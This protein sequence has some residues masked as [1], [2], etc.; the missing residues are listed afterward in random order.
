[1]QQPET[2]VYFTAV[3]ALVHRALQFRYSLVAV[4]ELCEG[5][6]QVQVCLSVQ[7]GIREYAPPLAR[8]LVRH[9]APHREPHERG[10]LS[11]SHQ[12]LQHRGRVTAKSIQQGERLTPPL[13]S[14]LGCRVF[15]ERAAAFLGFEVQQQCVRHVEAVG[16]GLAEADLPA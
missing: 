3:E 15:G 1:M 11:V 5:G 6:A 8:L 12:L 2:V 10:V 14:L 16:D 4:A 7:L 13:A 9:E